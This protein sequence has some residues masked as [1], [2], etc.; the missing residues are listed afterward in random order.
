MPASLARAGDGLV[1]PRRSTTGPPFVAAPRRA[2]RCRPFPPPHR[3]AT[4]RVRGRRWRRIPPPRRSA[5]ERGWV[6]QHQRAQQRATR[7]RRPGAPLTSAPGGLLGGGD[8]RAVGRPRDRKRPR[9]VVR[10][11]GSPQ[12]QA[13]AAES[14]VAAPPSRSA[15][16]AAASA[17]SASMSPSMSWLSASTCGSRPCSRSVA[18]VAGPIDTIR[19]LCA[20]GGRSG[21]VPPP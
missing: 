5:K 1:S 12:M 18:L 11:V 15:W 16:C 10:G 4:S 7:R 6:A 20:S 17:S 21:S 3:S 13:R 19:V 9:A 2:N 8:E 14:P